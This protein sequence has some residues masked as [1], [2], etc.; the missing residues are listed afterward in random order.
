MKTI[1]H[2][3]STRGQADHGWLKAK[4]SFSF[5]NYYDPERV[6]FGMLRVLND[7]HVEGGMGFGK[8]PHDNMEIVTIPLSGD[9]EHQDSMGH[10]EV[11]K[12]GEVQV[13]SAG[14]GVHHSEYNANADIPVKLLQIWVIPNKRMVT[15][16][17]DQIQ[18][19]QEKMKDNLLQI[20]SPNPDDEGT[21][22]HQNTWFHLGNLSKGKKLNYELKDKKN[23]VYAFLI[24]GDALVAEQT[25][26]ERDALGILEADQFEISATTDAKIL[27]IEV[28]MK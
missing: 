11:I 8:H 21:W 26:H 17:Y 27:L 19:V 22:V 25:I 14:T 5:A 7:D 9:L 1:L 15:P 28:P 20:V 13:M 6:N 23:G 2:K 3:S 12:S 18:L 24:E 16:R 4:H 10:T